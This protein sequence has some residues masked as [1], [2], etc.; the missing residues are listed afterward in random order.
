MERKHLLG[1][2]EYS[3]KLLSLGERT[4]LDVRYS[5]PTTTCPAAPAHSSALPA[6]W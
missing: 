1:S 5:V 3:E 6:M 2:L 4:V